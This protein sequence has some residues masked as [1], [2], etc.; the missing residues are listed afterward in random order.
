MS[1]VALALAVSAGL[2]A[3]VVA[4]PATAAPTHLHC[5]T[6]PNG[7]VHSI[8]QGVTLHAP[9]E[10]AFESFHSNVHLGPG[11]PFITSFDLTPPFTCPP[12]P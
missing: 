7:N 2:A 9:H 8:A 1:K 3:G 5:V 10:P 6:T 4:A 12:S 11:A